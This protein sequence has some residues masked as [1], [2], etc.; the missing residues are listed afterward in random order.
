MKERMD[1]SSSVDISASPT[2]L[3]PWVSEMERY[4]S[5]L[6][7]V[8]SVVPAPSADGALGHVIELRGRLGPF[9]RSKRLRMVRRTCVEP[10]EV[11][12]ERFELDGRQHA[13]WRL[14]A[15]VEAIDGGRTSRLTMRLGYDG[16]L[17]GSVVERL[18]GDEIETAKE[19]LAQV[20]AQAE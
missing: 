4:P 10:T 5:W 15:S 12:F 9:A 3:F 11:V 17:F 2:R 1:I 14:A 8:T 6:T 13:M 7:I 16:A 18:L 20:V 19:R